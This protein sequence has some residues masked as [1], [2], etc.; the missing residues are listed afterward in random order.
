MSSS[1]ITT[2]EMTLTLHSGLDMS[3]L[4]DIHVADSMIRQEAGF[5]TLPDAESLRR[6]DFSNRLLAV[7]RVEGIVAGS[8][9]GMFDGASLASDPYV[10]INWLVVARGYRRSPARIG[11]RLLQ[12]FEALS[13][14]KGA[15]EAKLL[16]LESALGFWDKHHYICL[17]PEDDPYQLSKALC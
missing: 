9:Y 6:Y 14:E 15:T 17:D 13:I 16:S 4:A 11:S 8:I 10:D 5:S 7:A 2:P 3:C 1:V 12:A